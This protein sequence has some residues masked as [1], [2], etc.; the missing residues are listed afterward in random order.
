MA[1]VGLVVQIAV[2]VA[3]MGASERSDNGKRNKGS[4]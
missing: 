1:A 2:A 3:E 4:D